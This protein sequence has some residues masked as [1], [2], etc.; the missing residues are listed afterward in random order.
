MKDFNFDF[1]TD[2]NGMIRILVARQGLSLNSRTIDVLAK[3]TKVN[4]GLDVENKVL[5]IRAAVSNQNVKAFNLY[6]KGQGKYAQIRCRQIVKA[7]E[8]CL[9]I[10]ITKSIPFP[11]Y[12]DDKNKLLICNLRKE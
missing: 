3:P 4:I 7:I 9:D 12:W 8:N 2:I 1:N 10:K 6:A 5:C 11:A